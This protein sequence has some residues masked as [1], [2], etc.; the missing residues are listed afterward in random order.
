MLFFGTYCRVSVDVKGFGLIPNLDIVSK[1]TWSVISLRAAKP[2][3]GT[4]KRSPIVED[5]L[6]RKGT[7]CRQV[8]TKHFR[9]AGHRFEGI[10]YPG[11]GSSPVV[12]FAT[13]WL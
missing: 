11:I 4:F 6:L 5:L 12:R 2:G 3:N 9:L 7:K 10:Y 13:D 8:V 1:L